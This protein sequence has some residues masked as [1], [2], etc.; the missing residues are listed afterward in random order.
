MNPPT[1][2]TIIA[3]PMYDVVFKTLMQT[4]K[5][6]SKYFVGTILGV[7]VIDINFDTQEYTYSKEVETDNII[8]EIK[9]IRM[10]FVATIRTKNGEEKKI[11][12]E[13]QQSRKLSDVLRFSSYIGKQY[14]HRN[15][16]AKEKKEKK[17][18]QKDESGTKTVK[19][20]PLVVIYLL[21]YQMPTNQHIAVKIDRSGIDI[22]EG[23]KVE[24]KDPLMEI[25]THEAYFIQVSRITE[26]MY[27]EWET[28]SELMKLLSLFEQNYF[29][30]QKHTKIYPHKI[31]PKTN[32][33]LHKMLKSLEHIAADPYIRRIMEEQ[34]YDK[35][36]IDLL[37]D[38]ITAQG[39]TILHVTAER[40]NAWNTVSQ[41]AQ[42]LVGL[43]AQLA[44]YQQRFGN[45][46]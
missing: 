38:K 8:E 14:I 1:P 26:Q 22:L 10:D 45:L 5:D 28:C 30:E 20:L 37:N 2:N 39:N 11:L 12:I 35:L 4:D 24:I 32:K 46:N 23:S 34:E 18:I 17:D 33:I 44:E 7:E 15:I 25:L 43:Q 27:A 3:N 9:V 42:E 36:E 29:V 16:E 19:P 6:F 41:Q 31:N 13:I 21:G 40:D